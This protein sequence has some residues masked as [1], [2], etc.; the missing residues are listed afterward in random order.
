MELIIHINKN[1][2]MEI[3]DSKQVAE[4]GESRFNYYIKDHLESFVKKELTLDSNIEEFFERIQSSIKSYYIVNND[5]FLLSQ[6]IKLE[7]IR[8]FLWSF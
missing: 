7:L 6:R 8:L 4:S 5:L 3:G 2:K 1:K